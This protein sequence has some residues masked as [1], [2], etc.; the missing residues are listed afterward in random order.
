MSDITRCV[1]DRH[2]LKRRALMRERAHLIGSGS[3]SR[4]DQEKFNLEHHLRWLTEK[5]T[6]LL[7]EL[8]TKPDP[9]KLVHRI[10]G[11]PESSI[12]KLGGVNR[13]VRH[14]DVEPRLNVE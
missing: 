11:F 9:K 5:C 14:G 12:G 10:E 4:G 7:T 2:N 8:D 13:P 3:Q 6:D 1:E